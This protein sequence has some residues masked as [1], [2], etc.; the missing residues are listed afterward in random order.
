MQSITREANILDEQ[1]INLKA[2]RGKSFDD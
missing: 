1:D 2:S